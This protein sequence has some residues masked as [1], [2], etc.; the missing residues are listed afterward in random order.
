LGCR[1]TGYYYYSNYS[2]LC[3]APAQR[4]LNYRNNHF[5]RDLDCERLRAALIE[6]PPP[7]FSEVARRLNHKRDFVREKF[8]EL[9]KA[10][11]VRYLNYQSVLRK[12][13]AQ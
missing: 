11:T 8:P 6:D 9:S 10:V 1:D 3:V 12:D 5:D 4:Y 2:N 13:K 7:S